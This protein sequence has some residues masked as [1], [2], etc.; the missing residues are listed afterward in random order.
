MNPSEA[1]SKY[2]VDVDSF[3]VRE[4]TNVDLNEMTT[5]GPEDVSRDK[6][7]KL[8]HEV[9]EQM[10]ERQGVFHADG[11]RSML[12]VLQAMDA[13]GK[14]STIRN[15][16]SHFDP[17]GVRVV[18]FKSPTARELRQDFLWRIHAHCPPKGRIGIFNRSHYEDVVI[19]RIR[20]FVP[21]EVWSRR[22]DHIRHFE[23]MLSDEGTTVLKFFLHMSKD[24]QKQRLER[25][26]KRPDKWWKFN[27]EDLEERQHWDEY[28]DVYSHAIG[29]SS[30]ERCPWYVIPSERRWLRNLIITGVVAQTLE[31]MDLRFPPAHF[32]PEDFFVE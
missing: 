11:R 13:G 3:R 26:L 21:E 32:K 17:Q 31:S 23:R 14:D 4:G 22:Y 6:G 27:P 29:H 30:T 7:E 24:Y 19:A 9:R 28:M 8:F 18:S 1:L 2:G 10:V 25:R 5:R 12:V 16:F 20:S 15:V